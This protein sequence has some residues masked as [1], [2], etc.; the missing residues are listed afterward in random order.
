MIIALASPKPAASIED[1]L[2]RVER[3]ARGAADQDARIVCFPE[4][5]LPGLRG[6]DFE[7]AR[8]DGRTQAHVLESVAGMARAYAIAIVLS[9]E[10]I[11]PDGSQIAAVVIDADGRLLGWQSKNQ[12]HPS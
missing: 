6:Q 5:Y 8:W 2:A 9:V 12:L 4:A 3:L 10:R 7:V 1:G 11:T